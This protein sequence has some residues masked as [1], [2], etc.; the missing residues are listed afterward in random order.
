MI[1]FNKFSHFSIPAI[2]TTNAITSG[3]VVLHALKVLEKKFE[4]CQSVYMRLRANPRKQIFVSEKQLE[5]P[6]PKCIVC[7]DKPEVVLQVDTETIT[8]KELRDDILI[9]EMNMISPDVELLGKGIIIISSEEG[10]TDDNLSKLLK[11]CFIVDGCILTVDDFFQNYQLTV[12]IIHKTPERDEAKFKIVA[13]KE[14]LKPVESV[15]EIK[16]KNSEPQPGPSGINGAG[17]SNGSKA[18]ES[19]DDDLMI[20]ETKESEAAKSAEKRKHIEEDDEDDDD[21]P[22]T[23]KRARVEE[24]ST[25]KGEEEDE[26]LITIDSD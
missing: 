20:V 18:Y 12:T 17:P 25:A 21:E 24:S 15:E 22:T 7:A 14:V 11:D 3:F 2:A 1:Q 23:M 8:V 19:D 6:N 9:K 26:D 4:Q 5:P 13:E 16:E 10:E